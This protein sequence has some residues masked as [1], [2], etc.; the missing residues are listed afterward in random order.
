MADEIT[1]VGDTHRMP[2]L[3]ESVLPDLGRLLLSQHLPSVD[4]KT[5][6]V[7]E[8]AAAVEKAKSHVHSKKVFLQLLILRPDYVQFLVD[9]EAWETFC[10]T[11]AQKANPNYRPF[12]RKDPRIDN[13]LPQYFDPN[14]LTPD[15]Y[16]LIYRDNLHPNCP[17]CNCGLISRSNSETQHIYE[18]G[19][20]R[21]TTPKEEFFAYQKELDEFR[22]RLEAK[23]KRLGYKDAD[24]RWE[25]EC[26]IQ[27][28]EEDER[29][30]NENEP[31]GKSDVEAIKINEVGIVENAE[32]SKET[33]KKVDIVT[34]KINEA[35]ILEN[36]EEP[37][38]P[39]KKA[40]PVTIKINKEEIL[41]NAEEA[42]EPKTK[43]KA[44][45]GKS[46]VK[47]T[48]KLCSGCFCM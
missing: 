12:P 47:S 13:P 3:Y 23:S 21:M 19:G 4:G 30:R 1:P 26:E 20:V 15:S 42:K 33:K 14:T 2:K 6:T 25:K 44:T 46:K 9:R 16:G 35:E 48:K 40:D 43:T 8:F 41:E 31:K 7:D 11:P 22:E 18:D 27:Q 34:I 10:G 36:A 32:E 5:V 28:A 45:S 37:E 38:E 29:I 39:K 24:E 17:N